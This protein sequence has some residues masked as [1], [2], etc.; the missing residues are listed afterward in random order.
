MSNKPIANEHLSILK[1]YS[2]YYNLLSDFNKK[3]FEKRVQHFMYSKKFIPRGFEIVTDEMR[4]LISSSAIQ[5]VFGLPGVYLA[6]FDKILVYLDSYYSHIGKRYH[7]GEVNPRAGVIIL[8]W[9]SFVKGYADLKDSLNLGIHEMAHA[10][11]FENR[12]KNKDYDF[13]DFEALEI[14]NEITRRE[15][16]KIREGNGHF[17]RNYA[18]TNQYEFFAVALEYFF[19][20]PQELYEAIPDLYITLKNLLNQDPIKLYKLAS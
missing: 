10:I 3:Q 19:E 18:G 15:I 9:N 20:N 7:Q 6:N 14:L 16:P 2:A 1:K 4:V 17:L 5:L 11:H 13:L 8:S 12:I